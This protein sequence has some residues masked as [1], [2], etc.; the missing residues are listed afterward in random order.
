M[1]LFPRKELLRNKD[2]V[3]NRSGPVR[4]GPVRSGPVPTSPAVFYQDYHHHYQHDNKGIN[5]FIFVL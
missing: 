5:F 3:E 2:Q 4:S 1:N